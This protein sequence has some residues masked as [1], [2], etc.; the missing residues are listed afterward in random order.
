M[1]ARIVLA[2][3]VL[4]PRPIRATTPEVATLLRHAPR[5]APFATARIH[6]LVVLCLAGL[7][8]CGER[9][10]APAPAPAPAP[11]A[12][13]PTASTQAPAAAAAAPPADEVKIMK[14]FWP[15]GQLKFYNELRRGASGKWDKNGIGRAYYQNGTLEREGSYRDGVRI[16]I[17]T[18]YN[19]DGSLSRTENRGG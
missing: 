9:P 10:S 4:V 19:A 1:H 7:S 12:G 5:P 14:E 2:P 11:T 15:G 13:A 18:Y 16:G 6:A 3:L 8:A 17:W